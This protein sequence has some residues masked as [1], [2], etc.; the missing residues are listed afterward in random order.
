M[1]RKST[2]N[3]IPSRFTPAYQWIILSILWFSHIVYFLNY[4]TVGTLAPLIQPELG[5]SSAQIGFLCSAITIGSMATQIPAGVLCDLI[6]VKWVMSLGLVVMGGASISMSWVHS[7]TGAFLVLMLLGLG[8]GCIQAPASKAIM[9]WFSSKGRATAMGIKQTGINIG[10]VLASILL[11][12]LALQFNSW[13]FSFRAAGFASL[14]SALLMLMFYKETYA[15]SGGSFGMPFLKKKLSLSHFTK[16]FFTDLSF[17]SS[18]N[19]DPVL[20]YDILY[21]LCQPDSKYFNPSIRSSLG[22]G[23]RRGCFRKGWL[24]SLK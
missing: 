6:G 5:L 4:L 2:V 13:R 9:T 8:I 14:F 7:Y 24:E 18:F 10:G 19:D 12:A 22:S 17:R 23:L 3:E 16:G 15:S 21:A 20:F 11:P 1:L